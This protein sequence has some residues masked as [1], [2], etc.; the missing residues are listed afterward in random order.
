MIPR[1]LRTA[2]A[3]SQ[4]AEGRKKE[5]LTLASGTTPKLMMDAPNHE[6]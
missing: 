4:L 6:R 2:F 3:G 1:A 5:G